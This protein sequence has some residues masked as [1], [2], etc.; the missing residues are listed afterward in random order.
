MI[1]I[2]DVEEKFSRLTQKRLLEWKS[3]DDQASGSSRKAKVARA[4][5]N[6]SSTNNKKKCSKTK[7]A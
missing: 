7:E 2:A 3:F 4:G 1:D 6:K 5:A